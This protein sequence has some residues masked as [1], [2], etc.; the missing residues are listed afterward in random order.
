[1]SNA[2]LHIENIMEQKY[3]LPKVDF[4]KFSKIV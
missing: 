4:Q 2:D 1:M 3:F